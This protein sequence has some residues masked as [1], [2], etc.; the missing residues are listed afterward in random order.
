MGASRGSGE[1]VKSV[2]RLVGSEA[3]CREAGASWI[4]DR[5]R[6]T[7]QLPGP[8]APSRDIL[9]V[10]IKQGDAQFRAACSRVAST[11]EAISSIGDTATELVLTRMCADVCKVTHLLR[12]H[13][14]DICDDAVGDFDGGVA[15]ALATSLAGPLHEEALEQWE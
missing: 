4:S 7:C 8:N 9:G 10:D 2:A 3:A 13:G 14:V 6:A 5:I 11:R 15:T 12:A 1:G